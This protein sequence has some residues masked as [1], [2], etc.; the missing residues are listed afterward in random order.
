MNM[1][2]KY[3]DTLTAS[4]RC[5][6]K[7]M[8]S[9]GTGAAGRLAHVRILLK[10]DQ[11]RPDLAIDEAVE[12]SRPTVERARRRFV[13]EGMD[14]A[15]DPSHPETPRPRKVDGHLEAHLIALACGKPPEGSVRWTLRLLAATA[16]E[17]AYVDSLSHET[18]RQIMK[19]NEL[20]PWRKEQWA[21]PPEQSAD[22]VFYME[23]VLDVYTRPEDPQQPLVTMD[24]LSKQL[25]D[26]VRPPLPRARAIPS[27]TTWNTSATVSPTS[28]RSANPCWGGGGLPSPIAALGL[29]GPT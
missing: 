15:L 26:E 5:A 13:E 21:I 8:I 24:G 16:V 29:T 28:S 10:A 19:K 23:D 4:E 6:L 17:L 14:V 25:V 9:S 12:V 18:T 27:V 2:K 11:D 22:F 20:Q 3:I 1:K 7:A